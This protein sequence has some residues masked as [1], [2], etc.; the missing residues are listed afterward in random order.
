MAGV[1]KNRSNKGYQARI[2]INGERVYLGTFTTIKEAE[3]AYL[4]RKRG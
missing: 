2:Q 4:D 1:F 3:K